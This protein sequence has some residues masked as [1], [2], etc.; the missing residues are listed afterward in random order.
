MTD[1]PW[2]HSAPVLRGGVID[3]LTQARTHPID[4]VFMNKQFK[5]YQ[6]NEKCET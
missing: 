6:L 5:K 4:G 3:R 1:N 2:I